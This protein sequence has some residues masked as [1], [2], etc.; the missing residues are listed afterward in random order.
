MSNSVYN[1]RFYANVLIVRRTGWGKT[2]FM[3]KLAVN[4][5]FGKLNMLE[6]VSYIK[7]DKSREAEIQSY[8]DGTVEFH[9]PKNKEHFEN[10]SQEFKLRSRSDKYLTKDTD[11]IRVISDYGENIKRDHLIVMDGVSGLAN[12]SQKFASFL[13]VTR[14]FKYHCVY[15][16]HII[17]PEKSVWKSI[18]SQTNILNIFPA[19]VSLTN[20]KKILES[21]CVH[22]TTG[23]VPINSL[24]LTMLFI[25][26]ANGDSKKTCLTLDCMYRF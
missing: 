15:I 6:W 13:T 7:T 25:K 17:H 19:S 22:K 26:L 1:G 5:F 3:Q 23:Y 21:N 10:L 2:H 4:N 18:L 24:W 8:F 16:F 12:T 11:S 20:L 14:K 9:Y